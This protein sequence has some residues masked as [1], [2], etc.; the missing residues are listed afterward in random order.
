MGKGIKSFFQ[1]KARIIGIGLCFLTV[2]IVAVPM[3]PFGQE[4]PSLPTE[5]D[6]LANPRLIRAWERRVL[7]N[8]QRVRAKAT[9]ELVQGGAESLPL[10]RHFMLDSS[11]RPRQ[12]AFEIIR[13]I[14]TGALPLLTELLESNVI[15]I[16]RQTVSV[17]IDLAPDTC[18]GKACAR[19]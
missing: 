6:L 1:V 14:G 17:F 3:P 4:S 5:S 9:A 19:K 18:L 2:C 7:A 15:S 16:R 11:D 8:D 12:E 10:L 13:R